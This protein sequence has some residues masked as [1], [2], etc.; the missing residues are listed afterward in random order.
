MAEGII[1]ALWGMCNPIIAMLPD[2]C[3]GPL[4]DCLRM[5]TSLTSD[6]CPC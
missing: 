5:L 4:R 1:G 3:G 6:I 2:M